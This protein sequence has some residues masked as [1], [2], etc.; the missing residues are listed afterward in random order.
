[1]DDEVALEYEDKLSLVYSSLD[2]SLIA[3]FE[4]DKQFVRSNISVYIEDNDGKFNMPK[5]IIW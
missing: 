2:H 4:E 1:M 5:C 3:R